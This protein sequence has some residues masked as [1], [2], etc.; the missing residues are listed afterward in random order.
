MKTFVEAF[1]NYRVFTDRKLL[2]VFFTFPRKFRRVEG[3]NSV[4]VFLLHVWSPSTRVNV[5]DGDRRFG[6]QA[7]TGIYLYIYVYERKTSTVN[8]NKALIQSSSY[9]Y[10]RI[11]EFN[12]ERG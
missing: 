11:I 9:I 8:S 1:H 6:E 5:K 4:F 10:E 2:L 3:D 7:Q 12:R